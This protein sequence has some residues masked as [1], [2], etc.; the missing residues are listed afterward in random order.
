MKGKINLLR[1]AP[2]LGAAFLENRIVPFSRYVAFAAWAHR[3]LGELPNLHPR[4]PA[5]FLGTPDDRAMIRDSGERL[6]SIRPR[7]GNPGMAIT[8]EGDNDTS[9]ESRLGP[10]LRA[11]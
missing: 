5:G 3:K 9:A 4:K 6:R 11:P 7:T 8:G 10:R 2:L 1:P